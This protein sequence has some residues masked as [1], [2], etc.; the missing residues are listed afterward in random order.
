MRSTISS[1]VIS[2]LG[3]TPDSNQSSEAFEQAAVSELEEELVVGDKEVAMTGPSDEEAA[4]EAIRLSEIRETVEYKVS[5]LKPDRITASLVDSAKQKLSD[6]LTHAEDYGIGMTALLKK[7]PSMEQSFRLQYQADLDRLEQVVDDIE[8]NVCGK[9]H[10]LQLASHPS[11]LQPSTAQSAGPAVAD[12]VPGGLSQADAQYAQAASAAAAKGATLAKARVK[13][14]TLLDFALQ[15]TQDMETDGMYLE[16]ASNEKIQKL[17]M[18]ISKFEKVRDKIKSAHVE[19]LEFTAVHRPDIIVYDPKKL[20]DTVD[21]A[22]TSIDTLITGLEEQ[23]DERQLG[24]LLPRKTERV[25]WPTFSGKSGESLFKFKEQFVKAARQNQTNRED[26]FTKLR[27]SLKDFPLTLVPE[28]MNDVDDAF[29]RLSETYGD[30]QKLVNYELKKLE[31]VDMFPNSDDGSYTMGTRAQAE[32]LLQVETVLAELIKMAKDP[33]VDRDL[34]RSVYGPQTT[35][36]LLAKFPLILKQKLVSAAKADPTSEKLDIFKAKLKV[37]SAE[38]LEMEKYQPEVKVT[39]KK[40]AIQIRIIQNTTIL[41]FKPPKPLPSCIICVELQKNQHVSP[42][43]PHLSAHV[44]GCPKF[45]QMNIVTRTSMCNTL[46]LCKMCMREDLAGHEKLCMVLKVKNKD[47]GKTKY[48][49]TC[50]EM[51]CYRHMW[52]CTKHKSVNQESMDAKANQLDRDHGLKLVHFL[53]FNNLG[54]SAVK[55]GHA[56]QPHPGEDLQPSQ[57]PGPATDS[58]A[59]RNAEKKLRKKA[60]KSSNSPV[61]IVPVPVGDPMFMFQALKGITKPVFAFYD[62]GCSNACLRTGIPGSQLKGQV[63]AKG[64]FTVEGVNGVLIQAGDEWLVHLDRVDGRK[65]EM[66][67]L[68]LDQITGSSP[69]FNIEEATMAVKADKPSDTILQNCSLPKVVG[70]TVDILIGIQYNSIFPQPIHRLTNGLEIY[71]CVLASHDSSINATIGGPHSSFEALADHHGGAAPV[72][73]LFLAGLEKFKRWGPPSVPAN[74][75]TIEEIEYAKSMNSL[76][77]DP[78]LEELLQVERAE[79]YLEEVW[80]DECKPEILKNAA[81]ADITSRK[82]TVSVCDCQSLCPSLNKNP[83][84][85]PETEDQ[86]KAVSGINFADIEKISPL[87][88]LKL[89]EDGGLNVEY[90]CVKFVGVTGVEVGF[91]LDKPYT[92]CVVIWLVDLDVE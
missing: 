74:P 88:K 83:A 80:D 35:S 3:F 28:H 32:W 41:L 11:V 63:L 72:M 19:Y 40:V 27:E 68:T 36:T 10:Q 5:R 51:F 21:A 52:L 22:L 9:I 8:E 20:D 61:E 46:K 62:S 4:E 57:V 67:G 34:H 91:K 53:G 75:I 12:V 65:Q 64:P 39:P 30:P 59:F 76:E 73:A 55:A 25:K 45:I 47:K 54:Q 2:G 26:Q 6:I 38:A 17:V 87:C 81:N 37:W 42:Q 78:I 89:L 82:V 1:S 77:G 92:V 31:K 56:P 29:K 15:T 33:D 86:E 84:D 23:D 70:G 16:T 7:Y 44:T 69:K 85:L 60:R 14:N 90:R 24:T 79:E 71:Q 66:R 43:L 48:E 58:K 49:F 18:K 13:Y 50:K